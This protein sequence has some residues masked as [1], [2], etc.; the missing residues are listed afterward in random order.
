[1]MRLLMQFGACCALGVVVA[2]LVLVGLMFL[3]Y[4]DV[5]HGLNLS[6]KP[7]ASLMLAALPDGFWHG[8]T[9]VHDAANNASVQSFLQLCVAMAQAALVLGFVFHRLWYRA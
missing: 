6:G 9:G 3:G 2:M 7:L 4:F 8:L 1:M 5:I